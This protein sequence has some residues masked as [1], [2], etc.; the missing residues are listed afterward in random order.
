MCGKLR[1]RGANGFGAGI[2]AEIAQHMPDFAF[3]KPDFAHEALIIALAK[4]G[5]ERPGDFRLVRI[6][7]R[8]QR[9]QHF[10]AKAQVKCCA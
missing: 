2:A 6:Y 4:V 9:L 3:G 8:K 5:F 10:F 1:K 7:R